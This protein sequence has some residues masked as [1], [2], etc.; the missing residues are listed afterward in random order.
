MRFFTCTYFKE[1]HA[2][3]QTL[4]VFYKN[5]LKNAYTASCCGYHLLGE[6]EQTLLANQLTALSLY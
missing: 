3:L 5:N 6:Y 1:K 4:Q 2:Y